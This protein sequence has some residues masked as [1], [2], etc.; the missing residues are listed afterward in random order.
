MECSGLREIRERCGVGGGISVEE[1]L[2]FEGRE[3]SG[4]IH[5]DAG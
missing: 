5:E 1:V 3:A 2:V 4:E